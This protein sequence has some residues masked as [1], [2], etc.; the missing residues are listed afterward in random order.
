M[1]EGP[2]D[3]PDDLGRSTRVNA[4]LVVV[5]DVTYVLLTRRMRVAEVGEVAGPVLRRLGLR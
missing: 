3:R 4:T 5:V 1:S 2:D